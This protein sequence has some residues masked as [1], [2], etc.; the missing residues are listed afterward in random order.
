MA[1]WYL[2]ARGWRNGLLGQ[3]RAHMHRVALNGD[4]INYK[5]GQP[6]KGQKGAHRAGLIRGPYGKSEPPSTA[7]RIHKN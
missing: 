5:L 4:F 2:M 3:K 6:H 1:L 7:K